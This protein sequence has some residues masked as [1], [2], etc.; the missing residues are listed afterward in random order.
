[1]KKTRWPYILFAALLIAYALWQVHMY[2]QINWLFMKWH[3]HVAIYIYTGLTV[4]LLT[5]WINSKFP[6]RIYANIK[7]SLGVFFGILLLMEGIL[8]GFGMGD[9]YM[10]LI[11]YGYV[12]RYGANTEKYYRLFRPEETFTT[13]RPE[14]EYTRKCNSLGIPDKEWPVAKKNG[15]KRILILGDSFTEGVGAPA[16]SSYPAILRSIY[17]TVDTNITIMNAGIA[18]NDPCVSFVTYRDILRKYH[19]DIVVQ[20]LSSNDMDTD[21]ATKGGLERFQQDS[22]VKFRDAPWWEPVYALSYVSRVFF[23]AAGYNQLLIKTPFSSNEKKQLDIKAIDLFKQYSKLISQ[24][25]A[26]LI[27]VLQPDESTVD[28]QRYSYDM[29]YITKEIS[30]MK[31]T[32]VHDMLPFYTAYFKTKNISHKDYYWQ[33]DHHHNS[34]GYTVMALAVKDILDSVDAKH[35]AK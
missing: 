4:F 14:F 19:P 33:Q 26:K 10:E 24:E 12:S 34:R 17:N 15:E 32:E 3:T 9:T 28:D 2:R 22:T 31:A 5:K 18:G 6:L 30:T 29:S 21:L 13:T 1:M 11:K 27:V 35:E 16:D 7:L 25:G 20:S 23:H 8:V